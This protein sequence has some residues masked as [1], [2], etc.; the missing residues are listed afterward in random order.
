MAVAGPSGWSHSETDSPGP[1]KAAE[2][3]YP[4]PAPESST[5]K[6]GSSPAREGVEGTRHSGLPM[7][8]NGGAV[9][10]GGT[11]SGG[12][13]AAARRQ[14]KG[15]TGGTGSPRKART[16]S[17]AVRPPGCCGRQGRAQASSLSAAGSLCLPPVPGASSRPPRRNSPL[18]SAL[19]L[20]TR[21]GF[22]S[23]GTGR[24]KSGKVPVVL[25]WQIEPLPHLRCEAAA[26]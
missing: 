3:R 18:R 13:R 14:G 26:G 12:R 23:T 21:C 24:E 22:G 17:A 7:M 16:G 9:G 8:S 1:P 10:E 20:L 4:G 25:L 15:I 11:G 5:G 19:L 6:A 2:P